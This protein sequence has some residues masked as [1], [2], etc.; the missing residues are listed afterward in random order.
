MLFSR[1]GLKTILGGFMS[2]GAWSWIMTIQTN[3]RD[4][5]RIVV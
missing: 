5:N 4:N 1:L 2:I 3:P